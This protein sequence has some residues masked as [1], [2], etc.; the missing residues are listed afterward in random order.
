MSQLKRAPVDR[1]P[2]VFFVFI[3]RLK[4][5]KQKVKK[6]PIKRYNILKKYSG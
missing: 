5:I 3:L 6:N 1:T 4:N 2:L